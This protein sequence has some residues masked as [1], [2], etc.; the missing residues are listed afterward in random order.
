MVKFSE[1]GMDTEGSDNG[2][3]TGLLNRGR[4]KSGMWVQLPPLPPVNQQLTLVSR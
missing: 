3:S 2:Y 4:L 1:F